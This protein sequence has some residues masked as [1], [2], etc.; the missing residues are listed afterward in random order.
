M[1][2]NKYIS[3]PELNVASVVV[4][5]RPAHAVSCDNTTT[6]RVITILFYSDMNY[7]HSVS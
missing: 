7:I 5:T 3:G 6:R 1:S 2:I 4:S